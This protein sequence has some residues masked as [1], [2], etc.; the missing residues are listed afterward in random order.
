MGREHDTLIGC[1]KESNVKSIGTF[2]TLP[3]ELHE[4]LIAVGRGNV[5]RTRKSYDEALE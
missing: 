1:S 4:S 2:H 3:S 5:S